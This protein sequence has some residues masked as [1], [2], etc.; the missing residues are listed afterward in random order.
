M[1]YLFTSESVSEGHPDKIAD[2]ISDALIDHFLA[3]D[4]ESK[5]ACE[6][7]VT[8][9]QV[10][11]AGEVKSGA[12]LD[13]QT[14]AREVINGIGYTKGEYMFNGDSCGVISAIHEQSPDIN[15]GVDRVVSDESFEAKANAQGAGDQGMMFGYAT[16]ETANYMP[17]ALD[18]AHT[19]LKELSAIRREEKDIAY[20]R[21]DA[22]SQV[23]IEY[24]DDH[25]PIRIDSIVVSTQ[26]D[27]FG[28]EGEMLNKIREDI[29]NILIP[30]VVA[31]QTE[32]IKAL[33]NDQIKYHIN[34][35]GKFVIGGP[36]GDTGL[37]GRK[38]IVDTY[39]G[40]GAHGGGAFSGKDPSKVDRSAAYATRHIAKN[41][42]AAGVADEV[43]V[44][45]SYAIGVAEPC[46][47]YI[48]TFGT[49][50]VDLHDGE[51]AEKV[52]SVFD[53]RPYAIE[54]NLKLRNPIYQETASYGHMGKEHYVAD[55]VFNKGH[56]NELTLKNLEFFTWEKLDKV[57]DIKK[58]FGI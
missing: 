49:T 48:N 37:T 16:N 18:L 39:G 54:Q 24:S 19:I 14:I 7:L 9:G 23:T 36:H 12:Y 38:I 26:H 42:V 45:V 17:L 52:S 3:Y 55:K 58:A 44:Q 13:V 28:T 11:L 31:K 41:L 4:K 57:D 27:D 15:Q 10:V 47:L 8:T 35:T 21:P 40:K 46:G 5:V 1:S 30:R 32:E 29:K 25:K 43:L 22:K 53:L 2:Q 20:L 33:F 6:T 50:K 34:P 56:K 51:I